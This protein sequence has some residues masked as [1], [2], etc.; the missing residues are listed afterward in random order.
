MKVGGKFTKKNPNRQWIGIKTLA[1]SPG[2]VKNLQAIPDIFCAWGKGYELNSFL[3]KT[4][5]R[6]F[7]DIY[8]NKVS[9]KKEG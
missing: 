3:R 4:K 6:A 5:N 1:G 8:I 2:E 9:D 7:C